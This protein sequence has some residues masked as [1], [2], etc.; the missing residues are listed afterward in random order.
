MNKDVSGYIKGKGKYL[1][2]ADCAVS[3][4]QDCSKRLTFLANLFNQTQ[5]Q[6][7]R[8]APSHAAITVGSGGRAVE[9]WTV[10]RGNC[11]KFET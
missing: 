9:R 3:C 2:S 7:F 4:Y 1:Y 8:E 10:N 5:S 11:L 6:L